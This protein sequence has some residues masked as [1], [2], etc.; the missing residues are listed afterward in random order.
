MFYHHDNFICYVFFDSDM[1]NYII[2]LKLFLFMLFYE[3]FFLNF[4]NKMK[5]FVVV[6]VEIG[7]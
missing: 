1:S 6:F 2:L 4:I 5:I 7:A 3:Y